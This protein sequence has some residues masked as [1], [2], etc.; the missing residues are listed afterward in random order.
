M[1]TDNMSAFEFPRRSQTSLT[2]SS[3]NASRNSKSSFDEGTL[4]FAAGLSD[5]HARPEHLFDLEDDTLSLPSPLRSPNY[6]TVHNDPMIDDTAIHG[7]T[8]SSPSE[9]PSPFTAQLRQPAGITGTSFKPSP[10]VQDYLTADEQ[11]LDSLLIASPTPLSRPDL[12]KKQNPFIPSPTVQQ[13]RNVFQ[14]HAHMDPA[15]NRV[16]GSKPYLFDLSILADNDTNNDNRQNKC[17]PAISIEHLVNLEL[18]SIG[19]SHEL[20]AATTRLVELIIR[21]NII[22]RFQASAHTFYSDMCEHLR[23]NPSKFSTRFLQAVEFQ[24]A[25]LT[26]QTIPR[27]TGF[28][29]FLKPENQNLVNSFLTLVKSSPSFVCATI[30]KMTKTQLSQFFKPSGRDSFETLNALHRQNALDIIFHSLFPPLSPPLQ[31]FEYFAFIVAFL[32][33]N[34][35]SGAKFNSF[36]IAIVDRILDLSSTKHFST[37]NTMLLGF[38]YEGNFLLEHCEPHFPAKP[39]DSVESLVSPLGTKHVETPSSYSTVYPSESSG[40]SLKLS[41]ESNLTSYSDY[42]SSNLKYP[43]PLDFQSTVSTSST[44]ANTSFPLSKRITFLNDCVYQILSHF[45]VHNTVPRELLI[46]SSI[47][48]SKVTP[49]A[50]SHTLH[51]LFI[52]YFFHHFLHSFFTSPERYGLCHDF[53]LSEKQV[54][55]ILIPIHE[56]CV[57]H[58][59]NILYNTSSTQPVP[60]NVRSSVLTLLDQ[61]RQSIGQSGV[62]TPGTLDPESNTSFD[63]TNLHVPE[64]E[65]GSAGQLLVVG[66][67]DIATLFNGLFP[68]VSPDLLALSPDLSRPIPFNPPYMARQSEPRSTNQSLGNISTTSLIEGPSELIPPPFDRKL[69][70]LGV[71]SFENSSIDSADD[72]PYFGSKDDLFEWNLQDIQDDIKPAIDEMMRKFPYLYFSSNIQWTGLDSLRPG[73]AQHLKLPLPFTEKWQIFCIDEKNAVINVDRTNIIKRFVLANAANS[74]LPNASNFGNS[75]GSGISNIFTSNESSPAE[76][77]LSQHERN[78]LTDSVVPAVQNLVHEKSLSS[79]SPKN[80]T[81]SFSYPKP[82]HWN[83]S[84]SFSYEIGVYRALTPVSTDT[85]ISPTYLSDVLF[86][87]SQKAFAERKFLFATDQH[88]AAVCLQNL[89]PLPSSAKHAKVS[90][91]V[92]SFVLSQVQQSI[93][94]K[95]EKYSSDTRICNELITPY[96]NFLHIVNDSSIDAFSLL[97]QLRTKIWYIA[98][99]RGT[100]F[101]TR[102]KDVIGALKLEAHQANNVAESSISRQDSSKHVSQGPDFRSTSLKRNSSASSLS[103]LTGFSSFKRFVGNSKREFVSKRPSFSSMNFIDSMFARA[104]YAGKVKLSDRESEATKRWLNGQHI[105]NF[106]AGEECIHRFCCEIDDLVKRIIGDVSWGSRKRIQ[107]PLTSSLL[108]KPDLWKLIIEVEGAARNSTSSANQVYPSRPSLYNLGSCS[109]LNLDLERDS[110]ARRKSIDNFSVEGFSAQHGRARAATSSLVYNQRTHKANRKSTSNLIDIFSS[111]LDLSG[112]RM[113]IDTTHSESHAPFIN[114]IGQAHVAFEDSLF[115]ADNTD[116]QE[117]LGLEKKQE[118]LDQTISNLQARLTSFIYSDIG[119]DL[120]YEG[121]AI[122]LFPSCLFIIVLGFFFF[123]NFTLGSETDKW[124]SS[125]IV[126]E[127]VNRHVMLQKQQYAPNDG[128]ESR[129]SQSPTMKSSGSNLGVQRFEFPYEHS[130]K[131]LFFNLSTNPSPMG[132]LKII[133]ELVRLVVSSLSHYSVPVTGTYHSSTQVH[134]NNPSADF[135]VES[136]ST[137]YSSVMD[138]SV[139]SATAVVTPISEIIATVEAK[140]TFSGHKPPSTNTTHYRNFPTETSHWHA[141]SKGYSRFAPNT[142]TIVE[143]LRRIVKTLE[144][145]YHTLFRDLQLIAAF[146]PSHVLDLTDMGKAFWDMSLAVLS[147]KEEALRVITD[148]ASDLFKYSTSMVSADMDV[149]F[150]SQWTLKDCGQL[151]TIGAK[152]GIKECQRELAIMH[153]S[154]PDLVSLS[155]APFAKLEDTFMSDGRKSTGDFDKMDPV[156]MRIVRHWMEQAA[157]QGDAVA[158]EYLAQQQLSPHGSL[159]T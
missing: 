86:K 2:S 102:A 82:S 13:P 119:F 91:S 109:S 48:L 58:A 95:V 143:E 125:P 100:A 158:E 96:C 107:S 140:R 6:Q 54:Q 19:A 70:T 104:E 116:Q 67:S 9:K 35:D 66:P 103:S 152:E 85:V 43:I 153:L 151:W 133:H 81:K 148:T 149:L 114:S 112:R 12:V 77:F 157:G 122:F 74:D 155:M 99:I 136:M 31:R 111:S 17:A 146:V 106:C 123:T 71:D 79:T 117:S 130:C 25:T 11:S 42:T 23:S 93:G 145:K 38:L 147:V 3:T 44:F 30:F 101:W 28:M 1:A 139:S 29:S 75:G 108:F 16:Y 22:N 131:Q 63:T 65:Y 61:F 39:S 118:E 137:P 113:S 15:S 53:I 55:Q 60:E 105:Q 5:L 32:M 97:Y 141:G 49:E 4:N 78:I 80:Y 27:E 64:D 57:Q 24:S 150:F 37:L 132:K 69:P 72:I 34:N 7:H 90:L 94:S 14:P 33:E 144:L 129:F 76:N 8:A 135:E 126:E 59:Q 83:P 51:F 110:L 62:A 41:S 10:T 68:S 128:P 20:S 36:G 73:K 45:A 92:N 50:Q 138:R 115:E 21:H 156:R 84:K 52:D 88:N 89:I 134:S 87:S 26:E 40:P 124:L 142:D 47:L 98:E 120:Y 18:Q 127:S 56:L 121:K 159:S 154:H 46:F